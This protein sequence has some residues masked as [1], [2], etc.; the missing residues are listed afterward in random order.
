[1]PT[2]VCVDHRTASCPEC[3]P[4]MGQHAPTVLRA[5]LVTFG[6]L[7]PRDGA[8]EGHTVHESVTEPGAFPR[9]EDLV[10][11]A[12]RATPV[13]AYIALRGVFEV[14]PPGEFAIFECGYGSER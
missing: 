10:A 9:V 3:F 11:A 12:E 5:W 1:M 4:A 13:G 8:G 14:Q 2:N 6:Y 7:S